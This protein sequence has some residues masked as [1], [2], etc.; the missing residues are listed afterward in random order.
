MSNEAN[1]NEFMTSLEVKR[2]VNGKGKTPAQSSTI[3]NQGGIGKKQ[4]TVYQTATKNDA[5][6]KQAEPIRCYNCNEVG[7]LTTKNKVI[8]DQSFLRVPNIRR[9]KC[10]FRPKYVVRWICHGPEIY[11]RQTKCSRKRF[12]WSSKMSFIWQEALAP[13]L[14]MTKSTFVGNRMI[15]FERLLIS[16]KLFDYFRGDSPS[17]RIV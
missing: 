1:N 14:L 2:D 5:H 16:S 3:R 4:R 12:V 10:F 15:I 6:A 13:T 7:Y 11:F 8:T 9:K 17:I